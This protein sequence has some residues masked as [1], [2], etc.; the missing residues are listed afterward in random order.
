MHNNGDCWRAL[1]LHWRR[2][3]G[4][5]SL[6]GLFDADPRR[7]A[8]FSASANGILLDYSKTAI[9]GETLR[10]LGSVARMANF[11]ARKRLMFDGGIV[12]KSERRAALHIALRADENATI[13]CG[14]E[15]I[16]PDVISERK[17]MLRF[18]EQCRREY[19]DVVHMVLAV[20]IWARN[21]RRRF[22]MVQCQ[23]AA[24]ENIMYP[25]WTVRIWRIALFARR[26][27]GY[28]RIPELS[29]PPKRLHA[30]DALRWLEDGV[31]L[32]L[33][34]ARFAQFVA[35]R[36]CRCPKKRGRLLRGGFALLAAGDS[37][38]ATVA[39]LKRFSASQFLE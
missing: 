23:N 31:G 34:R 38:R 32:F 25:I 6:R 13:C 14:G 27:D 1:R 35:I 20:P 10:L 5:E 21:R 19:A 22:A 29:Q 11:G 36:G 33:S 2:R 4:G 16:M 17:R 30:A 8:R 18:A 3:G 15:N 12:N 7:F 24:G 26:T 9:I 39:I 28:R 37:L